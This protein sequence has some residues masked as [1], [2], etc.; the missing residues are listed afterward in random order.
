MN[1]FG[2][3]IHVVWKILFFEPLFLHLQ[4]SIIRRVFVLHHQGRVKLLNPILNPFNTPLILTKVEADLA[5]EANQQRHCLI[6]SSVVLLEVALESLQHELSVDGEQFMEDIQQIV[7]LD[8]RVFF[9][10]HL[11]HK[12]D[13][14]VLEKEGDILFDS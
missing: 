10:G 8:G 1:L 2:K 4:E 9:L 5:H 14:L 13:D 11:L 3:D 7:D 12:M 6:E